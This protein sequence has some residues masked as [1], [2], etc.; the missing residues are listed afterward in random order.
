MDQ[1]SSAVLSFD[2]CDYTRNVNDEFR[3]DRP[4]VAA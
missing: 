1:E 2:T 3:V 4:E